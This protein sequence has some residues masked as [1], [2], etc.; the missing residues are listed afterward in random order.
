M[1]TAF[2]GKLTRRKNIM[3]NCPLPNPRKCFFL[4]LWPGGGKLC[5]FY[6]YKLVTLSR[7]VTKKSIITMTIMTHA[8]DYQAMAFLSLPQLLILFDH[9]LLAVLFLVA[10]FCIVAAVTSNIQVVVVMIMII[11]FHRTL[12]PWD[13]Q[14]QRHLQGGGSEEVGTG[15]D[16]GVQ[17]WPKNVW[18]WFWKSL[19][20]FLTWNRLKHPEISI[21]S[22][23]FQKLNNYKTVAKLTSQGELIGWFSDWEEFVVKFEMS[24]LAA[25]QISADIDVWV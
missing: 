5:W 13:F 2:Q 24:R 22:P 17:V 19:V 8:T 25:D 15:G 20:N 6:F 4:G 12:V 21:V 16:A 3:P 23:H 10:L 11:G 9:L 1:G 14:H 7:N 18:P